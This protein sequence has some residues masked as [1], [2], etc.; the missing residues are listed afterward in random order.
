MKKTYVKPELYFENFELSSN[1][2]SGCE[3]QIRTQSYGTCGLDIPGL[4]TIFTDSVSG[5]TKKITDG[6]QSYCY[7]NPTDESKLFNS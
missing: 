2:A 3:K 4:G 6:D 5:C 1:I 7:H